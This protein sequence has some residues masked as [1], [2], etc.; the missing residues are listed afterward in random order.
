M[1]WIVDW[2]FPL[3]PIPQPLFLFLCVCE[4]LRGCVIFIFIAIQ[5]SYSLARNTQAFAAIMP[6]TKHFVWMDGKITHRARNMC[7]TLRLNCI[8]NKSVNLISYYV[9]EQ[10]SVQHDDDD[11]FI[12][13]RMCFLSSISLTHS[14]WLAWW[15]SSSCSSLKFLV[16]TAIKSYS[17]H[18]ILVAGFILKT[19]YSD[20]EQ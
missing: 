5:I 2:F 15:L 13:S 20:C 10:T 6:M 4:K 14:L 11:D 18:Q 9:S 1:F 8:W 16:I 17:L 3:S 19:K 7:L 12:A